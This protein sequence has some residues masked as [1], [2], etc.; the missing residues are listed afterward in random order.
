MTI[1]VLAAKPGAGEQK[2][3]RTGGW[4]IADACTVRTKTKG[5]DIR[6]P[7]PSS[8]TERGVER[9]RAAQWSEMLKNRSK[10]FVCF[11]QFWTLT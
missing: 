2:G 4:E 3:A 1:N 7:I 8:E 11:E 10:L 6:K 9:R 5:T